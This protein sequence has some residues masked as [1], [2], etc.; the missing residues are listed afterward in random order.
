M[1]M[2]VVIVALLIIDENGEQVKCHLIKWL[3]ELYYSYPVE[4]HIVIQMN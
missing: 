3:N 4:Y 1:Q 2:K